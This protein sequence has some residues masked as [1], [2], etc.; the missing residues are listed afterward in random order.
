MSTPPQPGAAF[1]LAQVG[2]HAAARFAERISEVGVDPPDVGLLRMIAS[3]PGRSQQS[4]AEQLGVVPSRVVVLVDGLQRRGLVER[5]RNPQD[6]RNHALHLTAEAEQ[7]MT[8][9]RELA[10]THES[11]ICAALDD[12]QRAQLT[13]LLGAIAAQQGLTPGV[14][15]GYRRP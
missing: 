15:P 10:S 2:A 7:V 8:R 12:H 13:E 11:D 14:H 5:R 4:L 1:L 3:Q 6:R 9:I